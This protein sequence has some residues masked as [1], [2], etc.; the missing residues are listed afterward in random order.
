[1]DST[2]TSRLSYIS[3]VTHRATTTK[4]FT[5][6]YVKTQQASQDEFLK[7][8][9]QFTGRKEKRNSGKKNREQISTCKIVQYH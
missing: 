9:K 7:M 4:L 6:L 3:I 2:D 8:P 1:M 5:A